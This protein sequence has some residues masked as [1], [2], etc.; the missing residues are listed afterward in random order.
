MNQGNEPRP[1][2]SKTLPKPQH[3]VTLTFD[4]KTMQEL[5]QMAKQLN[6][7]PAEVVKKA[8]YMFKLAQGR[9]VKMTQKNSETTLTIKDFAGTAPLI[10]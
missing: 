6:T 8:Y 5:Y 7:T 2:F 9:T 10:K 1:Q 3:T 4:D